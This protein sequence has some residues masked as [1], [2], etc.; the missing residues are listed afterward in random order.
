ML[1]R[2]LRLCDSVKAVNER[3]DML[4]F[5]YV[6]QRHRAAMTDGRLGEASPPNQNDP[7]KPAKTHP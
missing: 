1:K 4:E 5:Q 3:A 2:W 6:R 7:A